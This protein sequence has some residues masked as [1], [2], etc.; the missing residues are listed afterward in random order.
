MAELGTPKYFV[1][2]LPMVLCS[3]WSRALGHG[4]GGGGGG[5]TVW[6]SGDT[7][8]GKAA[9]RER[10]TVFS[11]ETT[12]CWGC[13]RGTMIFFFHPRGS[14]PP[15]PQNNPHCS[16]LFSS[17]SPSLSLSLLFCICHPSTQPS[18]LFQSQ[19]E[20]FFFFFTSCLDLS[21]LP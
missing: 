10:A 4:R 19:L 5:P 18:V 9:F 2:L 3:L 1:P 8:N 14:S 21:V 17:P 7:A 11:H 13:L 20:R 15:Q 6:E 16:L 12:V